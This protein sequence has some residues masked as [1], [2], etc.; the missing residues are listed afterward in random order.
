MREALDRAMRPNE[1][2][3]RTAAE[4]CPYEALRILALG[5]GRRP[6]HD[7]AEFRVEQQGTGAG[8]RV[9]LRASERPWAS[10]APRALGPT[11]LATEAS[12]LDAIEVEIKDVFGALELS[13]HSIAV[14]R[15]PEWRRVEPLAFE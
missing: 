4:V 7:S 15:S 14:P 13:G 8:W 11:P 1:G 9:T 2:L 10:P 3:G 5:D 12:A 6:Q